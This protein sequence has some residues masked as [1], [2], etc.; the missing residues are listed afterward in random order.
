MR[1]DCVNSFE[2]AYDVACA[3]WCLQCVLVGCSLHL[4]TRKVEAAC[5]ST[6]ET[7]ALKNEH[8]SLQ[9]MFARHMKVLAA[10]F[11]WAVAPA[12]YRSLGAVSLSNYRS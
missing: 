9:L 12:L 2:H 1:D 5:T 4:Q 3:L 6:V 7:W 11:F 8:F 10:A